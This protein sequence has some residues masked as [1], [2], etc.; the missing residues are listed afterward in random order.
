MR[1]NRLFQL[2]IPLA[3]V[4][5]TPYEISVFKFRDALNY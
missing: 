2:L 3:I 5:N 1:E 4:T